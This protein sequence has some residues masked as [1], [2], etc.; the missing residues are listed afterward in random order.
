MILSDGEWKQDTGTNPTTSLLK[1][2]AVITMT[3]NF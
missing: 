2:N 3:E 1:P